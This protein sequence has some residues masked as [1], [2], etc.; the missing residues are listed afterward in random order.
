MLAYIDINYFLDSV[1]TSELCDTK[2][3]LWGPVSVFK[4]L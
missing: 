2:G 3:I 1:L 4:I